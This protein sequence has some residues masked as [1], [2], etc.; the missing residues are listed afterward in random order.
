M[1]TLDERKQKLELEISQK[2]ARLQKLQ[3]QIKT[4]ER[5][6]R[7]RRLIE[8]GALAEKYFNCPPE[9][10]MDDFEK[11]L[12]NIVAIPLVKELLTSYGHLPAEKNN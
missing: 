3:Q 5:K 9:M 12:A 7:T 2:K 6:A 4:E 1:A 11:L 10:T 8:R